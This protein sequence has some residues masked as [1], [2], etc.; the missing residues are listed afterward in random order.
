MRSTPI[1]ESSFFTLRFALDVV[2]WTGGGGAQAGRSW[3]F[4]PEIAPVL[5]PTPAL[6]LD[7]HARVSPIGPATIHQVVLVSDGYA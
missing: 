1:H 7:G 4:G 6:T 5:R 3:P 2:D